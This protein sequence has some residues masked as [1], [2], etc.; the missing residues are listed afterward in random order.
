[1]PLAKYLGI[2]ILFSILLFIGNRDTYYFVY[3]LLS[4]LTNLLCIGHKKG[5]LFTRD[6]IYCYDCYVCIN[7]N[8]K[9]TNTVRVPM[10]IVGDLGSL[11]FVLTRFTQ[12][13]T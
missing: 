11:M 7:T 12:N 5:C 8:C 3:A 10:R 6:K 4:A 2:R 13:V 1:M 9:S